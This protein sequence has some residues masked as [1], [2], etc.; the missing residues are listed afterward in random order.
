MI[1][2]YREEV[3][4]SEQQGLALSKLGSLLDVLSYLAR[5]AGA[6]EQEQEDVDLTRSWSDGDY[7]LFPSRDSRTKDIEA[8]LR[9]HN[10]RIVIRIERAE[11]GVSGRPL[12]PPRG[13]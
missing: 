12:D 13:V 5:L 1:R 10:N 8:D 3:P 9:I 7:V 2:T 11:H 6:P 4:M